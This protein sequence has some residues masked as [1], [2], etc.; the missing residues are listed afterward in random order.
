[1]ALYACGDYGGF[2]RPIN[3]LRDFLSRAVRFAIFEGKSDKILSFA[4]IKGL[5]QIEE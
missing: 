2:P 4:E 5:M 1:M 3:K